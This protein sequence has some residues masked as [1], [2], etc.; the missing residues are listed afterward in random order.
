MRCTIYSFDASLK[1][2]TELQIGERQAFRKTDQTI[3]YFDGPS[4][5]WPLNH[6]GTIVKHFNCS[7]HDLEQGR[8]PE[9]DDVIREL[10][11]RFKEKRK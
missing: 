4:V 5:L 11:K 6:A 3:V 9:C 10:E 2:I 8:W 1:N 7:L